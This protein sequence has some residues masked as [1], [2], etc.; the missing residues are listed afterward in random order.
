MQI[1]VSF[2]NMTHWTYQHRW[3]DLSGLLIMHCGPAETETP[4]YSLTDPNLNTASRSAGMKTTSLR[5]SH[6]TFNPSEAPLRR[7]PRGVHT[8]QVHTMGAW[9]GRSGTKETD[10]LRRPYRTETGASISRPTSGEITG[11]TPQKRT[12]RQS[13]TLGMPRGLMK[14][15]EECSLRVSWRA[16]G[17]LKKTFVLRDRHSYFSKQI[18]LSVVYIRHRA[19]WR[20]PYP[21]VFALNAA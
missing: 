6:A 9:S 8:L 1:S 19:K 7:L 4:A 15:S 21:K 11:R 18:F 14:R 17:Y 10:G 13:I 5:T 16:F 2:C 12:F 20:M 3:H